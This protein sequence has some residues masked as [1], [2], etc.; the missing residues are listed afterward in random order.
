[1]RLGLRYSRIGAGSARGVVIS[2]AHQRTRDDFKSHFFAP[3]AAGASTLFIL[4]STKTKKAHAKDN[5]ERIFTLDEVKSH[6]TAESIWVTFEGHVYDVTDWAR[7]HPGGAANLLLA[8]GKDLGEFIG[9]P[10]L[11]KKFIIKNW[12]EHD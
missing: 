9:F 11:I 5:S 12:F 2:G 8:A 3:L 6:N 10:I 4:E 7:S 1:M